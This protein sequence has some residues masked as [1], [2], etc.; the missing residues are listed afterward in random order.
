[1]SL[2]REQTPPDTGGG[3][4]RRAAD[5]A[6]AATAVR[7]DPAVTVPPD[8]ELDYRFSLANERTFLS[9]LR[10]ALA[11]IAGGVA[12][13]KALEFEQE[14]W[15]WVVAGPPIVAGAGLAVDATL[16]WRTYE[17]SMRAG[18]RLPVG[19]GVRLVGVAL[20]VYGIVVLVAT[21]L[22]G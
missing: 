7:H 5:D 10:T 20:G 8:D 17:S 14:V 19:R 22:D 4:G 6:L 21:V 13:A 9:W 15:R 3:E 12:A 18:R 2:C 11:L 16:R 1:M